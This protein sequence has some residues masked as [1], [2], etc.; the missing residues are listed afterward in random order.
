M[1]KSETFNNDCLDLFYMPKILM[2]MDIEAQHECV[3]IRDNRLKMKWQGQRPNWLVPSNKEVEDDEKKMYMCNINK[4]P[5]NI[6]KNFV[7]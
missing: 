7:K 1:N 3:S 5:F 6:A 2:D 4:F